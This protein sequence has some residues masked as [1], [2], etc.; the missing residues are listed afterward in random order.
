[1]GFLSG[2][3]G[4]DA[5]KAKMKAAKQNRAEIDA[6]GNRGFGYINEG[7]DRSQAALNEAAR[8]YDPYANTGTQAGN[9][10]ANA[11]GLNGAAGSDAA[12]AAFRAGP[13]YDFQVDEAMRG[14]ERAASAGGMLASG[15]LMAEMLARGQ[16]LANQEYGGWLDR[17][18]NQAGQGLQ[19]A[20]G[21]SGMLNNLANIYQQTTGQRLGLD[22][23]IVAG[24]MGAANQYAEGKE[25]NKGAWANLGS[26][27]G[28]MTGKAA[29]GGM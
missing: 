26:A 3:L 18:S 9:M 17:L 4:L 6:L 24:R 12:R 7:E 27:L 28:N 14:A 5:G 16:N 8:L 15:N 21:K 13:G 19:A 11:T 2:L 25:T 22:T 29:F 23:S 10:Y 20:Q 1:M